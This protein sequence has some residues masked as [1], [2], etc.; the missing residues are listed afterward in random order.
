M[1]GKHSKIFAENVR[2]R[3]EDYGSIQRLSEQTGIGRI[4]LSRIINEHT[5]PTLDNACRIAL[6]LDCKLPDLLAPP[7]RRR[8]K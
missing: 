4:T 8:K 1:L 5:P 3:C 7:R 6:A 2:R